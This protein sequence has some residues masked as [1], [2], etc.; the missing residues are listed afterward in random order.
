LGL[1]GCAVALVI[2][3]WAIRR[4]PTQ[5]GDTDMQV[6]AVDALPDAAAEAPGG[7]TEPSL[8]NDGWYV[9]NMATAHGAFVIEVEAE[10]PAQTEMIA[11]AL[12]EPIQADYDEILVYV[13]KVG[14][15]SDL[16]ARRMQWT[17]G[18]GYVEITYDQ[19]SP[20]R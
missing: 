7:L 13:N 18:G 1:V 4:V 6:V 16:P 20:N 12:I 3:N 11:H 9:R 5:T 17:P 14:D 10:D 15:E 2:V 19:P 8:V